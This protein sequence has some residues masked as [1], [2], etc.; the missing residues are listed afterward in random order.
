MKGWNVN[1]PAVCKCEDLCDECCP[2]GPPSN[3]NLLSI[4]AF[5]DLV[6]GDCFLTGWCGN[7]QNGK[8]LTRTDDPDELH[9]CYWELEDG[10]ERNPVAIPPERDLLWKLWI[11]N[12]SGTC[13]WVSK[14]I[15]KTQSNLEVV[16]YDGQVSSDCG[17]L[18][19]LAK[20]TQATN[21]NAR[22]FSA[23]TNVTWP[24]DISVVPQ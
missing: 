24:N 15:D 11:E 10:C 18:H 7:I 6:T 5:T 1:G 22:Q 13:Y 21:W 9:E 17:S 23:P 19:A 20:V 8:I 3:A 2:G 4:P 16:E 12:R 14:L